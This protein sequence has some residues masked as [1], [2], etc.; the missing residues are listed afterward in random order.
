MHT[1]QLQVAKT[2]NCNA[3]KPRVQKGHEPQQALPHQP[4]LLLL[5]LLLLLE[6]HLIH[7]IVVV[8]AALCMQP[9][10]AT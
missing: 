5:L 6:W 7:Q 10:P 8:Q 4:L 9:H 1:A 2:L 3:C